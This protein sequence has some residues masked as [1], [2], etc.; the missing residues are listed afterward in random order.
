MAIKQSSGKSQ[1]KTGSRSR[2]S[3]KSKPAAGN[4]KPVKKSGGS[5]KRG[6]TPWII[7]HFNKILLTALLIFVGGCVFRFGCMENTGISMLKYKQYLPSWLVKILPGGNAEAGRA[8]ANQTIEGKVISVADGDTIDI[9]TADNTKY[10]VRFFGIDAP[11]KKQAYGAE[12]RELLSEKILG[13]TVSVLVVNTDNYGRSVAKVMLGER[14]INLEMVA[15]GAAW[16]Y[17]AY[18]KNEDDIAQAEKSARRRNLGI[19]R[20]PEPIPPWEWRRANKK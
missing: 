3:G 11:E 16:H 1:T 8:V 5:S 10:R 17:V 9:L 2:N 18:A 4:R 12:A 20:D 19:W 15:E 14:Y 7:K 13:K 6:K